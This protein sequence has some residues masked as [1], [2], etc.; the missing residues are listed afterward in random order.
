MVLT[1]ATRRIILVRLPLPIRRRTKRKAT[2]DGNGPRVGEVTELRGGYNTKWNLYLFFVFLCPLWRI[3]PAT[4]NNW[5]ARLLLFCISLVFLITS[6]SLWY[7]T[8]PCCDSFLLSISLFWLTSPFC[9]M[10]DWCTNWLQ[11]CEITK[12]NQ[13]NC[14]S[15]KFVD[16]SF[17]EMTATQRKNFITLPLIVFILSVYSKW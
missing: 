7:F 5:T 17:S 8:F 1:A 12:T 9:L 10:F 6:V 15:Y 11:I 2:A 14:R 13:Y 3:G 4:R 16:F